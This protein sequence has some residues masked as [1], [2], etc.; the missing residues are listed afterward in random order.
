MVGGLGIDQ[1]RLRLFQCLLCCRQGELAH[2]P[3]PGLRLGGCALRLDDCG[4]QFAW[5]KGNEGLTLLDRLPL[6]DQYILNRAGNLAS[7]IDAVG[8]LDVAA[9]HDGSYEIATDHGIDDDFRTDQ[10]ACQRQGEG[11][12]QQDQPAKQPFVEPDEMSRRRHAEL[13][14]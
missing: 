12:G 2:L 6:V 9:C 3:H 1:R 7:D 10:P 4:L 13:L 5:L 8:C 11:E 14:R